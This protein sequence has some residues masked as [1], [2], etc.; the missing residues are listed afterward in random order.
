MWFS[1]YFVKRSQNIFIQ[2]SPPN[3]KLSCAMT[4]PTLCVRDQHGSKPTCASAQSDKDP[5]FSLI[6]PIKSRETNSEQHGSWSDCTDAQ[7]G[8]DPCW[9]QTHYVGFVMARLIYETISNTHVTTVL[10]F[11]LL[12]LCLKSFYCINLTENGFLFSKL[13]DIPTLYFIFDL[14]GA[15]VMNYGHNIATWLIQHNWCI[16]FKSWQTSYNGVKSFRFRV[17]L[18]A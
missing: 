3:E 13:S 1:Q 14:V 4:K 9:S 16:Q 2:S 12:W 11:Y 10:L 18:C 6:N 8:L 7:A 17:N 15:S 5:Q